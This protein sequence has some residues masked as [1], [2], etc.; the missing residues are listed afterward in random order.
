MTK[1]CSTLWEDLRPSNLK[2]F[3]ND[4]LTHGNIG[5]NEA[6][7]LIVSNYGV[8]A[9]SIMKLMSHVALSIL[10]QTLKFYSALN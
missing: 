2:M 5:A 10:L 8:S 9:D 1:D 6:L 7:M 3:Q 4:Y